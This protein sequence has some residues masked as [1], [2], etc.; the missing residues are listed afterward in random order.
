MNAMTVVQAPNTCHAIVELT[1]PVRAY[2]EKKLQNFCTCSA[3]L[4]CF[5]VARGRLWSAPY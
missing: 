4:T 2:S 5:S 3:L 1:A